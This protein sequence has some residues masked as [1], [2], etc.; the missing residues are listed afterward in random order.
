M[1]IDETNEL[2]SLRRSATN[3]TN[4]R[5]TVIALAALANLAFLYWAFRRVR[6][7]VAAR[8][9]AAAQL[10]TQKEL[11][12]VTLASI[13]DAVIVSDVHARI[14]FMNHEAQR[15]TGWSQ[16]E[17]ANLDTSRVFNIINEETRDPVPNPIER[18][19]R[20]GMVVGL[21]PH[22]VL[23]CK[24][25]QEIPIDD[26][27]APIRQIGGPLQGAVLVFRDFSAH[28]LAEKN[29]IESKKQLEVAHQSKDRFLAM[30]S[31]ELR[32]PLT[33]VLTTLS[34]WEAADLPD[35]IMPE[36]R[37]LRRNIELEARLIDDLL[38]INRIITGKLALSREPADVHNLLDSVARMYQSEIHAK[39]ISL[40][41]KLDAKSF[42]VSGDPAR[43]QQVFWNILKNAVKF[44]PEGKSIEITTKNTDN[45]IILLFRDTGIGMSSQTLEQIF[46]PF[47]QG[48]QDQVRTFGGLGL[49][50]AIAK[51]LLDAQNGQITAASDGPDLGSTFTISLPCIA[52]PSSQ[53]ASIASSDGPPKRALKIL[54]VEDHSDT[55]EAISRL[56]RGK[57]HR[58]QSAN[59]LASALALVRSDSFDVMLSDI[60][61]PDGTGI[62]LIREV[63]TLSSMPAVALSGFG[64]EDDVSRCVEAGFSAHLTKPIN[65]QRLELTLQRTV[66]AEAHSS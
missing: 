58:V 56:L 59:S 66:T 38:D 46:I 22:T 28:R 12:E 21:P 26:S 55:A 48:P 60:G 64:M 29:L 7:A 16:A 54:L 11:L 61:L 17:A 8:E 10:R 6:H 1:V 35:E 57:G 15:L 41:I 27:G 50:M 20:E 32:T 2:A 62:D 42:H 25:K 49:G 5:S 45:Q 14:T 47:Q 37:M 43:L 65:F 51:A 23:I 40:N 34:A 30:L 52:A 33:P 4:L 18:V 44:T 13:G 39:R 63:R 19:L 53:P 31:H 24:E 36:V 3:W 9:A